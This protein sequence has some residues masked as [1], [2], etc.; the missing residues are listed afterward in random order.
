M[1]RVCVFCGASSGR[2]PEYA[3]AARA[4]GAAAAARG[5]GIVYG[6]GRVGL[7]GAVADAALAAGGE[8]IGV[9]PQ[10]LV[11]R[12]LAHGGLSELRIVGSLHERK[13]LMAELSD[14]FVALPGGFGT[15]DEL[16]EQLTWSQLGLHEKPIGLLDV[17]EYWRP[18]IALAR[19]TTEEG[20]VR[21]SDLG[22]IAV[23]A[24][25][26]GLLDRLERMTREARPRPKWSRPPAP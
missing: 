22:A 23:G 14:G 12:E 19:H 9:I 11:D 6:G 25:A 18:L 2:L 7:M 5:L 16:F 17:E 15:L 26:E 3:E 10:E 20:F 1:R 13:A 24:D 4:F 21:E 8:V